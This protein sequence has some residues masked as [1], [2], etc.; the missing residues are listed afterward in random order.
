MGIID[1]LLGSM[2]KFIEAGIT[3]FMS[4]I[5]NL[6]AIIVELVKAVPQIITALISAFT[7]SFSKFGDIGKNIVQGLWNGIVSMGSWI[8][9]KVSDFFGGIVDG[10]KGLLG[11]HS[12]STVFA[13]IGGFMGEGLGVGFTKSMRSVE[14]DIMDAIPTDFDIE[15]NANVHSSINGGISPYSIYDSANY[16]DKPIVVSVPLYLDGKEITTATGI[17]QSERNLSYRRALGVT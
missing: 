4:L 9:D 13:N 12:P 15:A 11:I 17:I 1:G 16:S 8:K 14:N 7:N 6:P 5:T 10:V 3:L 2:D